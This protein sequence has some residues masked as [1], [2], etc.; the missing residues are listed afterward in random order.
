MKRMEEMTTK[1]GTMDNRLSALET[2]SH[3]AALERE[4]EK[5]ITATKMETATR[6]IMEKAGRDFLKAQAE[7]AQTTSAPEIEALIEPKLFTKEEPKPDPDLV[8]TSTPAFLGLEFRPHKLSFPTY[9]GKEDPLP[10][11]NRCEQ[12]FRDSNRQ[13]GMVCLLPSHGH[14]PTMVYVALTG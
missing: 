6:E 1:M 3:N 9:D 8:P 14:N 10:W 7:E 13:A 2:C 11:L 12:F 4:R 5:Q